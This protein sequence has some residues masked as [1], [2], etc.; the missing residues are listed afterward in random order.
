MLNEEDLRCRD[1]NE[2]EKA[3]QNIEL[4]GSYPHTDYSSNDR[5]KL[6]P[7]IYFKNTFQIIY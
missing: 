6:G 5:E 4:E 7:S 2:V 3:D 1:K